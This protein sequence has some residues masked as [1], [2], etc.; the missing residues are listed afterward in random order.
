MK[1]RIVHLIVSIL[2]MLG[3]EAQMARF[4]S[5]DGELYNSHASCLMQDGRGFLWV[6]TH[7]GLVRYDGH[8]FRHFIHCDNDSLTLCS[9]KVLCMTPRSNDGSFLVGTDIGVDCYNPQTQDFSHLK[10]TESG[11][12]HIY[13]GYFCCMLPLH[14]GEIL[15]AATGWGIFRLKPGEEELLQDSSIKFNGFSEVTH[16]TEDADG[17]VW[18]LTTQMGI[19]R[20]N[21]DKRGNV[22][23]MR[24]YMEETSP[25]LGLTSICTL[26]DGTVAVGTTYDGVYLY[27][28]RTD[29]FRHLQASGRMNVASLCTTGDGRLLIGTEGHGMSIYR[30]DDGTVTPCGYYCHEIDVTTQKVYDIKE[31]REGNVWMACFQ[32]GLLMQPAC[33]N[34]FSVIGQKSSNNI[35]G[36]HCVM[37][38][39]Q[40][41]DGTLWVGADNDG[42]YQIEQNQPIRHLVPFATVM[43]MTETADGRLWI[44]TYM[45]GCGWVDRNTGAYHQLDFTRSG[46]A[47][48][49]MNVVEDGKGRLW[50][51][52]N[53]DGLLCYEPRTEETVSYRADPGH[54]ERTN[55]VANN[56]LGTLTVSKD[57]R[58]LYV[59]MSAGMISLNLQADTF[60]LMNG[61]K[62]LLGGVAVRAVREDDRGRLWIATSKGLSCF[63]GKELTT[64]TMSD[65][66]PAEDV[67]SLELEDDGTVWVG[68]VHGLAHYNPVTNQVNCYFAASG[69]QGNEYSNGA[70]C[71]DSGGRLYFAG[72][73]GITYFLPANIKSQPMNFRPQIISITLNGREMTAD[74]LSFAHNDNTFT[75][76]LSTMNFA[77]AE[78]LQYAYRTDNGTWTML[79]QGSA[80]LTLSHLAPGKYNFEVKATDGQAESEILQFQVVVRPPLYA[81]WWAYTLYA[82]LAVLVLVL[83]L[84]NRQR[85]EQARLRL[86]EFIHRHESDEQRLSDLQ[87]TVDAYTTQLRQNRQR[88]NIV[89]TIANEPAP[90]TEEPADPSPDDRLLERVLHVVSNHITDPDLSVELIAQEVGI[91]RSHLHRKMKELTSQTTVDLIRSIRLQRAARLL[92]EGKMSVSDVMYACGFSFASSFTT[93]FKKFYGVSPTEYMRTMNKS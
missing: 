73:N 74:N 66:L 35:V 52:T 71:R 77:R 38:V 87:A 88:D 68:T 2:C 16:M 43:G 28:T 1:L 25:L 36:T 5:A 30:P 29:S 45:N 21:L 76:A 39:M 78:A 42:L 82:L 89:S 17:N 8:R 53:G 27:D 47:L 34:G 69:L 65:G 79:P 44:A 80:D 50:I 19:C 70:S 72:N 15:A 67:T 9:N 55:V 64:L 84:R 41:R 58:R 56:W 61:N 24:K 10:L 18:M 4:F 33:G 12:Q 62:V 26:P 83:Y 91:S 51:A 54:M 40:G 90:A 37:S 93:T 49:A 3:V 31:D 14:S 46:D 23:D 86:Q 22:T 57:R 48:H 63:D 81:T 7:Y 92:S 11:G 60:E 20:L 59:C 6:G 32:K 13:G 75:I 85:K